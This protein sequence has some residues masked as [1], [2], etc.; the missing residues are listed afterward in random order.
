MSG[1]AHPGASLILFADGNDAGS[2]LRFQRSQIVPAGVESDIVVWQNAIPAYTQL[3]WQVP[4]PRQK[5]QQLTAL[6]RGR[7]I[8]LQ[9]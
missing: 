1:F 8:Q 9:H 2:C 3:K 7:S 6:C 5:P 4:H